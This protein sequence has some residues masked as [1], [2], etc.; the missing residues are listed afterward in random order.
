M[1]LKQL[2]GLNEVGISEFEIIKK[3][4]EAQRT[5]LD[6]VD[7]LRPDGTVVKIHLPHIHFDPVM[8]SHD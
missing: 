3:L 5:D 1:S 6:E 8:E 4:R 7:F 2:L